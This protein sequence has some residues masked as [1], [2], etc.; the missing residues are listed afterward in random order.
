[1]P[2]LEQRVGP[3]TGAL[4][5]QTAPTHRLDHAR[6]LFG[7]RT[8]PI[9]DIMRF[10]LSSSCAPPAV[11]AQSRRGS[12]VHAAL[13]ASRNLLAHKRNDADRLSA[14][15]AERG[16]AAVTPS[17]SDRKQPPALDAAAYRD[18]NLIE[19]MFC[20]LQASVGSEPATISSSSIT[21][22]RSASLPL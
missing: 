9:L 15:L 3:L 7:F 6:R 1:M 11:A 18:R 21:R 13:P 14:W 12:S 17:K 4:V 5:E 22:V 2:H 10:S 8:R 16:I 20:R 19:H